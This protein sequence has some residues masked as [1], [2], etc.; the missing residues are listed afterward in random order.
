MCVRVYIQS[1][2][3]FSINVIVENANWSLN[4]LFIVSCF[5][6]LYILGRV[7]ALLRRT[8][9]RSVCTIRSEC[10]CGPT[11][12]ANQDCKRPWLNTTFCWQHSRL[13][14]D[15]LLGATN[16][17]MSNVD[18]ILKSFLPTLTKK[19]VKVAEIKC[20]SFVLSTDL[21]TSWLS[22]FCFPQDTSWTLSILWVNNTFYPLILITFYQV[23]LFLNKVEFTLFRNRCLFV[24]EP[25]EFEFPITNHPI[26]K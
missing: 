9:R 22:F 26:W 12:I 23:Q 18:V 5:I 6:Y 20:C 21:Q 25:D 19:R 4:K 13:F 16:T 10:K 15:K 8:F 14:L 3:T 7:P 2:Y 17:R 24:H 11:G 1:V